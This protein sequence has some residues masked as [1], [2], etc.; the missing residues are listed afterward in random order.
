[1]LGWIS[2]HW[3]GYRHDPVRHPV[4]GFR[5]TRCG[6]VGSDLADLGYADS[7]RVDL[8]RR[9]YCRDRADL[10]RTSAW[11]TGEYRAVRRPTV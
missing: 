2:C 10:T 1:M 7:S 5:C 9:V 6:A 4:S 11:D 8:V 3:L